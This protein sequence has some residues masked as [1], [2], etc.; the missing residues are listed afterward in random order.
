M[1]LG[2]DCFLPALRF[3]DAWLEVAAG[4]ADGCPGAWGCDNGPIAG[5][6]GVAATGLSTMTL[7]GASFGV[8][9]ALAFSVLPAETGPGTLDVGTLGVEDCL[10]SGDPGVAVF[11]FSS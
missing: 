10:E 4:G 6:G 11:F 7:E 1:T 5:V 8:T 9:A 3:L 2:P